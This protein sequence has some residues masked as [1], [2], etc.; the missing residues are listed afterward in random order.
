[1]A[2][3][4]PPDKILGELGGGEGSGSPM[5]EKMGATYQK[6]KEIGGCEEN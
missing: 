4:G 6:N 2:H 5:V 3:A 1:M